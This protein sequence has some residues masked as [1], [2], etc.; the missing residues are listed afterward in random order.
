MQ[1]NPAQIV[2]KAVAYQEEKLRL[3]ISAIAIGLMAGQAALAQ[4]APANTSSTPAAV[5][6]TSADSKTTAAPVAGKNSFTES[7]VRKRLVDHGYSG[8]GPLTLDNASV[9]R[10]T[11]T[12]SG[13][14]MNVAVDYQGN[15]VEQ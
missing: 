14:S 1:P 6:T 4:P 12:K 2:I 7:E 3:T 8:I 13:K 10:G 5:S 9:W 11:A 15:I